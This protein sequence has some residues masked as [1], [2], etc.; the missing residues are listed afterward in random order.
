MVRNSGKRR[1]N[2][3]NRRRKGYNAKHSDG[4]GMTMATILLPGRIDPPT[5]P[6]LAVFDRSLLVNATSG[7]VGSGVV[8]FSAAQFATAEALQGGQA[9][10]RFNNIRIKQIEVWGQAGTSTVTGNAP[11]FIQLSLT[12]AQS[13]GSAF[14]DY[15]V[16]GQARPHICVRP[17]LAYRDTWLAT[18]ATGTILQVASAGLSSSVAASD[19]VIRVVI[20]LR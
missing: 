10:T 6:A 7:T 18:N 16:F 15:G 1:A 2:T 5:T 14:V 12:G 19:Y 8:T 20:E 3:T 11:E 9:A 17:N 13:D 4:M